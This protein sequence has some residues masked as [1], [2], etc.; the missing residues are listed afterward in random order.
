M[1]FNENM[2]GGVGGVAGCTPLNPPLVCPFVQWPFRLWQSHWIKLGA[3]RFPRFKSKTF[4]WSVCNTCYVKSLYIRLVFKLKP[5]FTYDMNFEICK[6]RGQSG[7]VKD[8]KD[9][10]VY[11]K[12][13]GR[14]PPPRYNRLLE[15]RYASNLKK[16]ITGPIMWPP[17]GCKR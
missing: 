10:L 1:I 3:G 5:E 16:N 15:Y 7:R 13:V 2:I 9:E 14:D 4:S 12:N 6:C 17:E 8:A 11:T